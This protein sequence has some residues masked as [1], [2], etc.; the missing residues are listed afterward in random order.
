MIP[1]TYW[2]ILKHWRE[3][4]VWHNSIERAIYLVRDFS[5]DLKI[6]D[7]TLISTGPHE[8]RELWLRWEALLLRRQGTKMA[9]HISYW[10]QAL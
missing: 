1:E 9:R 10:L 2:V 3:M 5:N 7:A 8:P 6:L 4:R